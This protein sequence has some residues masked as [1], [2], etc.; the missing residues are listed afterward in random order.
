[1]KKL[2]SVLSIVCIS[3]VAAN[4]Q[5][6]TDSTKTKT[7]SDTIKTKRVEL[8]ILSTSHTTLA[9]V[10]DDST[11]KAMPADTTQKPVPTAPKNRDYGFLDATRT[12]AMVL[13]DPTDSTKTKP[14]DS[15]VVKPTKPQ[16]N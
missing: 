14:A 6:S 8:G 12:V 16:L 10:S 7:P 4:A 15:T 3:S 2:I 9:V 1:M 11:K 13:P 5:T